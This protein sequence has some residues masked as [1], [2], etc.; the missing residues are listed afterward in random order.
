MNML[1]ATSGSGTRAA[2]GAGRRQHGFTLVEMLITITLVSLLSLTMA[3]FVVDWLQTASLAQ[4]RSTLL[5]NAQ[6]A[7]DNITTDI[8]LSGNADVNNRWPDANGPGGNQFG[9]QSTGSTLVLA[10]VAT[11][12]GKKVIFS[13]PVQYI[14]EK[15]NVIYYVSNKVLYRRIIASD[16]PTT[17]AVT[18]CPA[19]SASASCPADSAVAKDVTAFSITYYNA[20]D[21]V[22]TAADARAVQLAITLSATQGGKTITANYSTRMVFRNE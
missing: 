20:D 7:L 5:T 21:Q 1:N 13:D 15:D 18:T 9:W 10:R 11:T 17:A 2:G 19:S 16:N 3:N 12:A 14:T 6:A 8:R 22:V 4:A